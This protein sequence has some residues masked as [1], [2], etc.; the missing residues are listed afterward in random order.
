MSSSPNSDYSSSK[1]QDKGILEKLTNLEQKMEEHEKKL[2]DL[3]GTMNKKLNDLEQKMEGRGLPDL[4][5][6]ID[7]NLTNL[8]KNMI[9]L[10]DRLTRLEGVSY[11]S[12]SSNA[13]PPAP[14]QA[15]YQ[16]HNQYIKKLFPGQNFGGKLT[17]NKLLKK[18]KRKTKKH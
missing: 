17:R 10:E 5:R 16:P 2:T 14:Q 8:Q 11:S 7:H 1:I 4:A 15:H 3:G 9:E 13:A 6:T 18:S 12:P